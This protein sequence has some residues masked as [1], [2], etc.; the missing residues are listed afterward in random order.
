MPSHRASTQ[1]L[2]ERARRRRGRMLFLWSASV[3]AVLAATFLGAG[4][5]RQYLDVVAAREHGVPRLDPAQV[6]VVRTPGGMLELARLERTEEFAWQS[7]YTCRIVDCSVFT[8]PTTST[9]R[10]K[11]HYV[12]RVPLADEWRL[13]RRGD[14]YALELPPPQLQEP[15]AF[16]TAGMEIRT[17]A[18]GLVSPSK[19][20]NRERLLRELG[21]ELA[22]RGR[23]SHYLEAQR[24][25]AQATAAEFAR[26]WM[27][28]QG[29]K[30]DLP[31]RVTFRTP[32][33]AP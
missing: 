14:H 32:P 9:A 6:V 18:G 30:A 11:A 3:L 29:G 4:A 13:E 22:R 16:D 26:K 17:E 10:V 23:Q 1:A 25:A 7:A 5:W 28:E 27:V 20:H 12:W 21:P 31:L 15:V 19:L 2:Q 33:A 8:R 24:P